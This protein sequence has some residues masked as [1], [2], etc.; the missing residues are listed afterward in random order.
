MD[1]RPTHRLEQPSRHHAMTRHTTTR[2]AHRRTIARNKP[3]CG[4]CGHDIDYTLRY[5]DLDCYVVDH[6]IP[7]AKGGKDE[8]ANKQP[9]HSR[10]NRAKSDK[11]ETADAVR[12]FVTP[13][14]W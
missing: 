2:D 5:P 11:L 1:S 13:R 4:I 14:T 7:I 6:I 12:T 3:P 9:A 8:L 10:C